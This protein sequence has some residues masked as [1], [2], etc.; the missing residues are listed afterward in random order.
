ML[1]W[2]FSIF[3]MHGTYYIDY[4]K[5]AFI[6]QMVQKYCNFMVK[7]LQYYWFKW[8]LQSNFSIV[9]CFWR[10]GGREESFRTNCLFYSGSEADIFW[11]NTLSYSESQEESYIGQTVLIIAVFRNCYLLVTMLDQNYIKQGE[12]EGEISST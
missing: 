8:K 11:T 1:H 10:G 3:S 12:C 6:D 7:K 2:K 4:L 5:L 9:V